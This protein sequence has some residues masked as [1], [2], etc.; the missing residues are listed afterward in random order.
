MKKMMC[1]AVLMLSMFLGGCSGFWS[2][3][4]GTDTAKAAAAVS[5]GEAGY[6]I[7]ELDYRTE[8]KEAVPINLTGGGSGT[9]YERTD[10]GFV[11]SAPG[12]YILSGVLE[13]GGVTV[14]L[15]EDEMV[16]LILNGVQIRADGRPAIYIQ[17]GDKAVITAKEGTDNVL[18]DSAHREEG[19]DA[20]IFSEADLTLNGSG[21]L[22]VFG[23]HEHGIRSRDTVKAVGSSLYVKAKL[24]GIRGNN[25]VIL[26]GSDV[27]VECEGNGIRAEDPRDM[28]ILEGGI[29]KVIAGK[30]A[31]KADHYVAA[32][33]CAADLYAV[34][35]EVDCSGTVL[36]GEGSPSEAETAGEG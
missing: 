22:S 12:E 28:I 19:A 25:G 21:R 16:H 15:Y 29:C 14:R 17:N 18:S 10:E 20:C 8:E 32:N 5:G 26:Y 2:E 24:D 7:T 35:G 3:Q 1:M 34:L 36:M 33:G 23:F 27:E 30:Y 31:L 11:I 13:K 4:I 6:E 9:G